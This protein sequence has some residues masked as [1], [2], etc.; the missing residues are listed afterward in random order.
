MAVRAKSAL[1]FWLGLLQIRGIWAAGAG[2]EAEAA[3][4]GG[5][6]GVKRR[7]LTQNPKNGTETENGRDGDPNHERA[8]YFPLS[9]T[10]LFKDYGKAH[11]LLPI[12]EFS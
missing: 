12:A 10:G 5:F 4:F 3:G 8:R 1:A 11:A 6:L 7:T 9:T 2:A